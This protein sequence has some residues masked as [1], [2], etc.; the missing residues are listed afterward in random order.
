MNFKLS[1]SPSDDTCWSRKCSKYSNRESW[2]HIY[3]LHINASHQFFVWKI[4]MR[5]L[6]SYERAFQ[7]GLNSQSAMNEFTQSLLDIKWICWFESL[8]FQSLYQ[9]WCIDWT[10][11]KYTCTLARTQQLNFRDG[12][13]V[14]CYHSYFDVIEYQTCSHYF[15]LSLCSIKYEHENGV[16]IF[17]LYS[18][19]VLINLQFLEE[20]LGIIS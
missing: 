15:E 10:V 18:L 9:I 17:S 1:S 12:N 19:N 20:T 11:N 4:K 2:I 16:Y 14:M 7:K 13:N 6:K 3:W 8:N 5:I